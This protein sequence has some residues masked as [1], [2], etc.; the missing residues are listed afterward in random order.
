RFAHGHRGMHAAVVELDPLAD[1]V[2]AG[3][4]DDH[5]WPLPS[6][7]LTAARVLRSQGSGS[8]LISRVE[9]GGLR[10]ELGRAGVDGL[11]GPN[12]PVGAIALEGE[13]AELVQ[14]PRVD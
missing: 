13:R 10:L 6:D 3:A 5:G 1:P 9:V 7:N 2:G 8:S 11:V 14:E 12:E 4:E